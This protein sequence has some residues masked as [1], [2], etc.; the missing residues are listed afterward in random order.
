VFFRSSL[1]WTGS[2]LVNIFGIAS[3]G[4][5]NAHSVSL[6]WSLH[7]IGDQFWVNSSSHPLVVEG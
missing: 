3:Y 2:R 4:D 6:Y 5:A 1:S 7:T